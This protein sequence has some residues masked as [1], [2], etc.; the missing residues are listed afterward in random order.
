MSHLQKPLFFILCF[1]VFSLNLKAETVYSLGAKDIVLGA[2]ALGLY[3]ISYSMDYPERPD[4]IVLDINDVNAFDRR[5]M[6]PLDSNKNEISEG[7]VHALLVLPVITV[8][9]N[10]NMKT[11]VT[12][13]IMYSEAFFLT[14][15][16]RVWLKKSIT[17]NRPYMYDYEIW[18]KPTFYEFNSFPSG[19]TAMAFLGATFLTTTLSQEYP[20][21]VWKWPFIFG[22][23][24]LAAWAGAI[25]LRSGHHYLTDVLAGAAIGSFYGWAVPFLHKN[26]KNKNPRIDITGNGL[27]VSLKL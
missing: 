13:G 5:L 25:R 16:T 11:L 24:S 2:L 22:S 20:E 8:F 27:S 18:Y 10:F 1:F 9:G 15:G 17:R 26:R 3:G 21:A 6:F 14:F 12:Y 23:Y 4:E 7:I 19:S